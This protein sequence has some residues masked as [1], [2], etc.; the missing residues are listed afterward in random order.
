MAPIAQRGQ[1]LI[2]WS[3][4]PGVW[5]A[6]AHSSGQ[7]LQQQLCCLGGLHPSLPQHH[8]PIT[9][10][11]LADLVTGFLRR[12]GEG[13]ISRPFTSVDQA[14]VDEDL[15]DPVLPVRCSSTSCSHHK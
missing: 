4:P 11:M 2:S 12:V 3:C 8:N 9:P 6:D 1:R 7:A 5:C 14:V 10:R 13:L 15:L